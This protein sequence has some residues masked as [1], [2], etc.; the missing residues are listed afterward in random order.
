MIIAL[1]IDEQESVVPTL[2]GATIRLYDTDSQ[3]YEDYPNIAKQLQEGRR[4]AVLRFAAE[5]GAEAFASPPHT[6]CERSYAQAVEQRIQFYLLEGPTSFRE[7]AQRR[8][9]GLLSPTDQLP[10]ETIVAS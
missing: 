3:T 5:K 7:F 1:V 10:K 2:E 4:S 9:S 8:Q 6:F